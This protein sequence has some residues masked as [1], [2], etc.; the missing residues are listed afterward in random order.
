MCIRDRYANDLINLSQAFV[1]A[2]LPGSEGKGVTDVLFSGADSNASHDFRGRLSFSWP[3]DPCPAPANRPDS[4]RPPLFALGYGLSYASPGSVPQLPLSEVTSCGAAVVL[5]IFKSA[6]TFPFALHL[7][8]A[9][10]E[11]PLGADLNATIRWP[12]SKPA[13]QVRTV[14]VLS[15]IHI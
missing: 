15:L 7:S 4:T 10:E 13:L 14:Q 5:P 11:R 8:A 1:A 6:D 9:G 12:D 2:W 3:N